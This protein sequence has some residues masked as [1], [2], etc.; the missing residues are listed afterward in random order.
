ME[1]ITRRGVVF[2]ACAGAGG[3]S[4]GLEQGGFDI[5]VS[6]D[7]E[8]PHALVHQRNF[9][10]GRSLQ[11]D[12]T[13]ITGTDLRKASG[14]G[15]DVDLLGLGR[16]PDA[17]FGG[18]PCQGVSS[19]GRRDLNDP[20]NQL[21]V[22]F[23]RLVGEVNPRYAVMENVPGLLAPQFEPFL[24]QL[25]EDYHRIGY[26]VVTPVRALDARLFGVPQHRERV[27]LL[28]HR[29]GE[30]APQYPQ[31]TH[32]TAKDLILRQTPTVG[33]ALAGLPEADHFEALLTSDEV[34]ATGHWGDHSLYG[35]AMRGLAN[36]PDDL[37]YRRI[38]NP[39]LLTNSRRVRHSPETVARYAATL[40]G[41]MCEGH[42]VMRLHPQRQA[43][44][45]RAGSVS[46]Q[47]DGKRV[48]AQ[49]A[50]RPIHPVRDRVITPR[51][52][53]RLHGIP[54]WMRL[55][56]TTMGAM[57]EIGNSVPPLLGRAIAHE[58]R[59]AA[60]LNPGL[61]SDIIAL[62]P[63]ELLRTTEKTAARLLSAA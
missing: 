35:L 60:G 41:G 39:S 51:E 10:Y 25:L 34:D 42:N 4:L 21:M 46:R 24:D 40:A 9:S 30:V 58:I 61:P 44:T 52:G 11:A 48:S 27:F 15:D 54:D 36:D 8:G 16:V 55:H 3:L 32:A 19:I 43:P 33:E 13:R 63:D 49:T 56:A 31:A 6:F 59:K 28:I 62:G 50:A 23:Q 2:E 22:H 14:H 20:R 38:W 45:L 12:L 7:I 57:R 26:N 18:P 53:A 5:K 17:L 29:F 37:S 47:Y 1:T